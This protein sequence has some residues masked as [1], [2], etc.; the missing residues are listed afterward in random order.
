MGIHTNNHD[1]IELVITQLYLIALL[2]LVR[3][4]CMEINKKS[5]MASKL[6]LSRMYSMPMR[7]IIAVRIRDVSK[8]V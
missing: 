6:V 2:S 1:G 3:C 4:E 7:V 5:D 8:D